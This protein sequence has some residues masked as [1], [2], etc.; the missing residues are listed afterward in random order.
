MPTLNWLT[1][2]ED[3]RATSRVP[4]RLLEMMPEF[5]VE[6]QASNS[7]GSQSVLATVSRFAPAFCR[8]LFQAFQHF[9][10][11]LKEVTSL[12]R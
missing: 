6:T 1:R 5:S 7:R 12:N 2:D 4:Y 10:Q 11:I 8:N 3:I 9:N